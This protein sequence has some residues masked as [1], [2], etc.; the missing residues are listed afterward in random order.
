MRISRAMILIAVRIP[1]VAFSFA[2]GTRQDDGEEA[3]KTPQFRKC[4]EIG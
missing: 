3:R 1:R 4:V 2:H